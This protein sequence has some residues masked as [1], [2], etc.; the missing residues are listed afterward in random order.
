MPRSIRH[1]NILT[2]ALLLTACGGGGNSNSA[3]PIF[4][5]SGTIRPAALVDIDSD[6]NDPDSISNTPNDTFIKPQVLQN[7]YTVN[8][9]ATAKRT[10]RAGDRFEKEI[11]K[12]DIFQVNLQVGQ[13]IRLQIVNFESTAD[14][15][16]VFQGDL[17]LILFNNNLVEV[18]R[19]ESTDEFESV[20]V[21][22]HDT[23]DG[24]YYIQV[25]AFDGTS[26]YVLSIDPVSGTNS[27]K[28]SKPNFKINEAIIKFKD[29]KPLSNDSSVS[30]S[31]VNASLNSST[32]QK[33]HNNRPL[34]LSHHSYKRATLA[35][36]SSSIQ[37]QAQAFST[38]NINSQEAS[39]FLS[40]LK[41]LNPESYEYY[42]TLNTIKK[43]R[44]RDDVEYAQ[45]NY[46]RTIQQV[47]NDTHY[48]KQWH[49]PAINLPQAW[50]L[51][52]GTPSSG[53]VIVAVIDTGIFLAHEDLNDKFVPGYDFISDPANSADS[54]GIDPNPDDPG[55]GDQ[56]GTSSWHGTHVAGTISA[57]TNNGIGVS[58]VSWG[59]KIM[60]LRALGPQGGSDYDIGQAALFAAGL[61]NDSN[62]LPTQK[63]DIINMS[64][65]GPGGSPEQLKY[66]QDIFDEVRAEGVIVVAA[67]G[68]ESSS[69]PSYPAAYNGVI[70]VSAT[71]FNNKLAPYSNFGSSINIAA[72]GGNS[73]QDSNND[74]FGDGVLSTLVDDSSGS[75]KKSYVFYEGTS[76]AAPHVAG[77]IA[78]MRAV[79]PALSPVDLDSL[80]A[81]GRLTNDI[82]TSGRDDLFGH[83]LIDALKAVKAAQTL[84][85]G[86]AAPDLP[87]LVIASP[88]SLTLG[89]NPSGVITISN[90]GGGS[91]TITSFNTNGSS[92]LTLAPNSVATDGLG[93]YIV[94]ADRTKLPDTTYTDFITFNIDTG[95]SLKTLDVQVSMI[96]GSVSTEG[97]IGTQFVLLLESSTGELIDQSTPSKNIDGEYIY[98]FSEVTAGSYQILSGSDIDNDLL[99]CQL[100]ESCGGYPVLN[101]LSNVLVTDANIPG[102]DFVSGVL[103][104]FGATS[105]SSPSIKG[106]KLEHTPDSERP[107]AKKINGAFKES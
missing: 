56:V 48:T 65:G 94:S 100:G 78:L 72:P 89:T 14:T 41:A 45:P 13:R 58:G 84:S 31:S 22:S 5:V 2:L 62:T 50:D 34:Q 85:Y 80:L 3:T 18:G 9:F 98:I 53:D 91:P 105:I 106:L 97:D 6:I 63:A 17:D 93:S 46:M 67:A 27:V 74:G 32:P 73:S 64:V 107:T 88:S 66:S 96:V 35:N 54:D 102:L 42:M 103:S 43:L 38:S 33:K 11:D 29:A 21:P 19:S 30:A 26:K 60:P 70:S 68:N 10:A 83:G 8:G 49:Y 55:D 37:P 95:T 4:A 47:P 86:G 90:S 20:T 61:A 59:A 81:A 51:T 99:I 57:E 71:D 52:T 69:Q 39:A 82:G 25:L 76:M 104:N 28:L 92:W 36:F 12:T 40:E 101:K 23:G 87:P 15:E 79:H 16:S 1:L 7:Y 75:R 77:V 24:T 44:L